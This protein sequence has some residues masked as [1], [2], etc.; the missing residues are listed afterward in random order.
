LGQVP[1]RS[2]LFASHQVNR[3]IGRDAIK[4]SGKRR[5]IGGPAWSR[6]P[7]TR[8]SLLRYVIGIV[9]TKTIS[10]RNARDQ[11]TMARY[12]AGEGLAI[13]PTRSQQ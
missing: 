9:R 7:N 10:P 4:P 3:E 6:I 12:Q 13:S 1:Y 5:A 2:T 11:A 8:E